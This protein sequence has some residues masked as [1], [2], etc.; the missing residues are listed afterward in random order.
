[1]IINVLLTLLKQRLNFKPGLSRILRN[2]Q[3]VLIEIKLNMIFVNN[4][5]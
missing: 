3:R 2:K 5:K 4:Y 1:M